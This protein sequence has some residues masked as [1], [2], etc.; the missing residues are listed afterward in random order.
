VR[1]CR[2]DKVPF[3]G[4]PC[5]VQGRFFFAGETI[6]PSLSRNARNAISVRQGSSELAA[7]APNHDLLSVSPMRRPCL[8]LAVMHG[9]QASALLP[10]GRGLP[11]LALP[12]THGGTGESTEKLG[13]PSAG[14]ATDDESQPLDEEALHGAVEHVAGTVRRCIS[15]RMRLRV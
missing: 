2:Q 13:G 15:R 11:L 6:H 5:L 12:Q 9:T 8:R 1:A 3:K 7:L 4:P 14:G 10:G